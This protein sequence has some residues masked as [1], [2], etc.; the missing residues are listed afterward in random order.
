MRDDILFYEIQ[1]FWRNRIAVIVFLLFNLY[2]ISGLIRQVFLGMPFGNNP[3]SDLGLIILTGCMLL[4]FGAIFS[5]KLQTVITEEGIYVRYFPFIFRTRFFAWENIENA[6]IR[7]YSPLKE[8]GGW[9]IRFKLIRGGTAYNVYGNI[10]LQLVFNN[11]KKLLIGTN[12]AEELA[13][14]LK[15]INDKREQK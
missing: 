11:G 6:Y 8:Y 14:V 5:S 7:K 13:E 12:R 4:L 3:M 2:I 15:K 9:G 1:P 10:G